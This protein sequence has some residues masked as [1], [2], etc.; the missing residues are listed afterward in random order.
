[1][2]TIDLLKIAVERGVVFIPGE[3]FHIR[4]GGNNTLRLSFSRYTPDLIDEGIRRLADS[5]KDM[6]AER[7]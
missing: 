4:E 3:S 7:V 5:I 1:M 2:D 6:M